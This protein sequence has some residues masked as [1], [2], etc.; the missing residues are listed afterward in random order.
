MNIDI[1]L[2]LVS[3]LT[4]W[5]FEVYSDLCAMGGHGSE[6]QRLPRRPCEE[7]WS[8]LWRL[9]PWWFR[10][11]RMKTSGMKFRVKVQKPQGTT[12]VVATPIFF[13]FSSRKFP[14][15]DSQLDGCIFFKWVGWF[16]H[17]LVKS[18][19]ITTYSNRKLKYV[20]PENP[21]VEKP[22]TKHSSPHFSWPRRNLFLVFHPWFGEART[23]TVL[24][25]ESWIKMVKGS[26]YTLPKTNMSPENWVWKMYFL[27]K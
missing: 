17:Q 20:T 25:P 27:L 16:N 6:K 8:L 24:T 9:L 12:K 11:G 15:N 22:P 14:G 19:W 1:C 23:S 13:G 5:E 26:C 21:M 10:L 7:P 18:W 2:G 4:P 3:L